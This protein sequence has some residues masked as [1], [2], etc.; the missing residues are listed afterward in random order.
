MSLLVVT[1]L[2]LSDVLT[3]RVIGTMIV[4]AAMLVLNY[5]YFNNR[6]DMFVN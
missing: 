6:K 5:K 2:G 1:P 3:G 4:S